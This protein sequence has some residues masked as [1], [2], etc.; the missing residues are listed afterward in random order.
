ML[1]LLSLYINYCEL[2]KGWGDSYKIRLNVSNFDSSGKY[3][4]VISC[5]YLSETSYI[6]IYNLTP[7]I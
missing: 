6:R 5:G 2:V 1:D 4:K 7:V 3:L